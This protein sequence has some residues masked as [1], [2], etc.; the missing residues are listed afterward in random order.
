MKLEFRASSSADAEQLAALCRRVLSVPAESPMFD[1]ALLHWKYWHSWATWRGSRSYVL[2]RGERLIAHCAVMPLVVRRGGRE[3]TLIYPLDWAAEPSIVGSG[4]AL[5]GQ[6]TA[7]ADGVVIVGG[8]QMTQSMAGPLGF[9]AIGPVECFALPSSL[10]QDDSRRA[11]SSLQVER[12]Q[13]PSSGLLREPGTADDTLRPHYPMSV[14][15]EWLGCPAAR[16]QCYE[17][18]RSGSVLGAFLLAFVP[19]QA[20]LL[21]LWPVEAE[22]ATYVTLLE[23]ARSVADGD[24]GSAELVAAAN[25]PLERQALLEAGFRACASMPM[26]ASFST[27]GLPAGSRIRYQ[28]LHSDHGFLHHGV[29]APWSDASSAQ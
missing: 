29:P 12:V 14:L 5:L 2:T 13:A 3:L 16:V 11:L 4:V 19:G 27:A 18:S 9:Q 10:D 1:A 20:R 22:Q 21:E 15:T 7:L 26:F 24:S 17:V 6:V 23:A 25:T 8:S 28:L